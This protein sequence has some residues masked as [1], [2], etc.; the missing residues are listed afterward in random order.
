MQ[1][2]ENERKDTEVTE[3]E[4]KE[5]IKQKEDVKKKKGFKKA[6]LAITGFIILETL[7]F[8]AGMATDAIIVKSKY[9]SME[10]SLEQEVSDIINNQSA[11]ESSEQG[12]A[13]IVS[14]QSAE[15][16]SEQGEAYIISNESAEGSSEQ[17]EADRYNYYDYGATQMR[18]ILSLK[19]DVIKF[20]KSDDITYEQM[21]EFVETYLNIVNVGLRN[22]GIISPWAINYYNEAIKKIN[23]IDYD[24]Y[25][26]KSTG[27][28]YR[29][30]LKDFLI[31]NSCRQIVEYYKERIPEDK[32]ETFVAISNTNLNTITDCEDNFQRVIDYGTD[33]IQE[34]IGDPDEVFISTEWRVFTGMPQK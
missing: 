20:Y 34:Y 8:I 15:E 19:E 2:F 23:L 10:K 30:G 27:E 4:K 12:E 26:L 14:N 6:I 17:E 29:R 28:D 25:E 13:D 7:V 21:D 22:E 5:V 33:L 24:M 18:Q 32:Y 16:S 3:D 9:P 1:D 11:E 31:A